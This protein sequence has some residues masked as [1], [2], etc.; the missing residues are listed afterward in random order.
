M[1]PNIDPNKTVFIS[2][3][4]NVSRYIAR[5][6]FENLQHHGYE[7][8]LD[9]E[10]IDSGDWATIILNQIAARAHF[11]LIL[12]AGTLDR[13]AEPN[14]MLRRE[15]EQ[16]IDMKRNIVPV[17]VDEFGFE[18]AKP[19][20]TGKL[21][22][23]PQYNALKLYYDYFDAGM[24]KARNRF[25]KFPAALPTLH[26]TPASDELKVEK[27]IKA[28]VNEPVPTE[29]ELSAEQYFVHAHKKYEAGNVDEAIV[30]YTEAIRLNPHYAIA[31][32]NRGVA[33][34]RNAKGDLDGAIADYTEAL[35]LNPRLAHT[36]QNR[37]NAY[38]NKRD[39]VAASLDWDKARAVEAINQHALG[40]SAEAR[41][42][43]QGLVELDEGYKD[44]EWVGKE[45]NWAE[46]LVEEARKVIALL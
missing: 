46:P 5:A 42:L 45:L 13:C 29:E 37:G 19:Y 25:L 6:I 28:A 12:T 15:I 7:P 16:A 36:Y 33:R 26:P 18:M 44:A 14:D 40:N 22:G 43:W 34:Y 4:R 24:E 23:L 30:D 1:M 31:Y 41:R 17:L 21:E 39:L 27:I 9:V 20:L 11:L 38:L 35:R 2:Y 8:F 32:N 10:G 3:R